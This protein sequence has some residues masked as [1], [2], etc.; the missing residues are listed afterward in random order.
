[1]SSP[2]V[3]EILT[4]C[5][6]LTP[7]HFR[8]EY[9]PGI[10]YVGEFSA[11]E[12]RQHVRIGLTRDGTAAVE[13]FWEGDS[14]LGRRAGSSWW[15]PLSEPAVPDLY[16][17]AA[18]LLTVATVVDEHETAD[19]WVLQIRPDILAPR[20]DPDG[21]VR[22]VFGDLPP[23]GRLRV[24]RQRVDE[25]AHR[26]LID[27]TMAIDRPSKRITQV[28]VASHAADVASACRM[29]FTAADSVARQPD[30]AVPA[31]VASRVRADLLLIEMGTVG[32]WD[33]G[34]EHNAWAQRSIQLIAESETHLSPEKRIY[35]EIYEADFATAT[36]PTVPAMDKSDVPALDSTSAKQ[37]LHPVILGANY[38]DSTGVPEA[39][40]TRA[41][42]AFY[43]AW[44]AASPPF[45]PLFSQP[46]YFRSFNHFGG[47]GEGLEYHDWMWFVKFAGPGA[48]PTKCHNAAGKDCYYSARDWGSGPPRVDVADNRMTF[49]SAVE[50]YCLYTPEGRRNAYLILGHVVHLLQDQGQPDHAFLVAHQGS[51]LTEKEAY[52][53]FL[54]CHDIAA[55]A[56]A[57]AAV[58]CGWPLGLVCGPAA[59]GIAYGS[60]EAAAHDNEVGFERLIMDHWR[61][62]R[63]EPQV[64]QVGVIRAPGRY[65]AYFHAM[66]NVAKSILQQAK[67]AHP[68]VN[69]DLPLG[70]GPMVYTAGV[71]VPGNDPDIDLSDQATVDVFLGLADQIA[72]QVIGMTAGLI[73]HFFD[74]VN[75]PPILQ[76]VAVAQWQPGAEPRGFADFGLGTSACIRYD[77]S[78]QQAFG[79]RL[80][81]TNPA[82][83]TQQLS[84]DRP[85]YVFL[86]FGPG[87]AGTAHL[88][89]MAQVSLRVRSV[90]PVAGKKIDF[91]VPLQSAQDADGPYLWG[92]F[93]PENCGN[94]PISVTLEVNGT[95]LGGHFTGR[96][97][98]GQ[99]LDPNPATLAVSDASTPTF[100]W[101]NYVPGPD[102]EHTL[103]IAPLRWRLDVT[104]KPLV[105]QALR[106]QQIE[107]PPRLVHGSVTLTLSQ[108]AWSCQSEPFYGPMRCPV[109]WALDEIVTRQDGRASQA[110][111]QSYGLT[112]HLDWHTGVAT[113][114]VEAGG[115]HVREGTY[116]F[117]VHC[118][119]GDP[120][121]DHPVTV[122]VQ[123]T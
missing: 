7:Y 82:H 87:R 24:F 97:Y 31:P 122:E 74:V 35:G 11:R 61:L 42:P 2:S 38:E 63:V 101:K 102:R 65:D 100:E 116:S 108:Q 48:P 118:I 109:E 50:Q 69:L 71:S 26:L 59:Y 4:A 88:R 93:Q 27:V 105:L 25:L 80:L 15:V 5:R 1:M 8:M 21:W 78:W 16:L 44:F 86:A 9:D 64:R 72:P 99:R 62:D 19:G 75:P 51:A 91:E 13:T 20:D 49:A 17:A 113:L 81:V 66:A 45:L 90:Q 76:R 46:P 85:A 120:P 114:Q 98:S 96:T 47:D 115:P 73:T 77:A 37:V 28:S 40:P 83:P 95:D 22:R 112:A 56:A 54:Y 110:E 94:D 43:D 32:G 23:A 68:G 67:T 29:T 6:D 30:D 14:G 121:A 107:R 52:D 119:L 12:Q 103:K 55:H 104:P 39:N 117:T 36:Y 79:G 57:A 33:T 92:Q 89:T 53:K 123:V 10:F 3:D 106:A 34:T 18:Q 41:L 84:S 60:C 70:C 111:A 58:V